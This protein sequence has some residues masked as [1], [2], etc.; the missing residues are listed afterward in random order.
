MDTNTPLLNLRAIEPSDYDELAALMDL[1]FADVGGAWPRM[2]IMDLIHQFPD[3]QICIEDSGKIVGAA[4]TIKVNYNRFSLNHA[5]TDIISEQNVIQHQVT[6]DALYGLDVF[7]HPD[8]RGL[9]LGRRL[10]DARKELCRSTNLKAILAGGRLP[11]YHKVAD[12]LTVIEYL[13]KVKRK[14]I[15]DPI[16]SFQL[17]NDFDVKRLMKNYLPED[18]K[19]CGYATL[20]EWDNVFYD[21]EMP[22]VIESE[23]KIVRIGI[24][25]WQMR[26]MVSVDDLIDQAEFFV[27]SLSNYQAD[28][29]LFPEFF[30]APLMGLRPELSPV[31]AI[32][33]LSEFSEDIKQRFSQMAVT[34]NINIISGSMP[35]LENDRLYNVSYLLHRD[36]C[37]DEQYKIHIT[38]H[39]QKDWVIDGGD[40]VKVFET[41][42]G[43]VGILICYDAEFPELGRMLAEQGVQIMFVPFWTDTK[44]GYLRVRLCAQARA[45]ENEC[46]VALGGSVGNLPRVN[47]VDIQYAQSAVF[48]PSD[49]YFPHD[50]T[51]TE[52]SANTEMII[53]ADVELD[54]LKYLNT[55]GSVT[56]LR[57]RRLDLY[58]G[59]TRAGNGPGSGKP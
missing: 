29:A 41:D 44:N 36:G 11:G 49:I 6:G 23:K 14:E 46:Y 9:R 10:Y 45:I 5:Y 8:Y 32:R 52:A 42:A 25:Q 55:E 30:N 58:G 3:G 13:E 4:L 16:L 54:K 27:S 53:F 1:V 59:F 7:V 33:F 22:S 43:R 26:K 38:P 31:E 57:H 2:T 20:L 24:V 56:N 39:E 17:A 48:S 40:K 18:A 19:S 47:N 12:Q 51:I 28:F 21:E 15:H 34:Y 35:I 37:I 50:A